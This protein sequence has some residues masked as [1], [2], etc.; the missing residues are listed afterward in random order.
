[1]TRII[2]I[3][4]QWSMRDIPVLA[5]DIPSLNEQQKQGNY[6]PLVIPTWR[7]LAL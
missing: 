2:F 1:M 6:K 4:L 5:V 7:Q 3:T